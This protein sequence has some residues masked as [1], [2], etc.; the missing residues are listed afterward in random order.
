MLG[1]EARILSLH[2]RFRGERRFPLPFQRPRHQPVFRFDRLVLATGTLRVI[3]DA[4]EPLVPVLL[5]LVP[6][7]F[8][9][10]G[11]LET[12]FE[13]CWFQGL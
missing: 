2:G 4:L 10:R 12:Q 7:G 5:P 13:G 11:H 8:H 3:A 9:I 6:F 1:K